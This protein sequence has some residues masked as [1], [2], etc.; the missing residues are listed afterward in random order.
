MFQNGKM[1]APASEC[2]LKFAPRVPPAASGILG[3]TR[4][5]PDGGLVV[6]NVDGAD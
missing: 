1:F 4:G 2:L 6:S 3:E 5:G